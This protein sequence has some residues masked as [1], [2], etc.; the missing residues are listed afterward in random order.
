[1]RSA[2]L[3]SGEVGTGRPAS[4]MAFW[5]MIHALRVK[6]PDAKIVRSNSTSA[7]EVAELG[8]CMNRGP[9]PV[10]TPEPGTDIHPT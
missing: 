5:S 10:M 1:M 2:L 8:P 9:Y 4:D 7:G 3:A 6:E